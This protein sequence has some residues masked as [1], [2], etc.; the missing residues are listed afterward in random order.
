L[1]RRAADALAIVAAFVVL[2]SCARTASVLVGYSWDWAPDEGLALDYARRVVEAPG[3]LYGRDLIPFPAAYT[4]LLPLL[5]APVVRFTDDPLAGARA[6]AV[7]WTA[8]AALGVFLLVRRRSGVALGLV[9]VALM[10][11]PRDFSMWFLLVRVDGLMIALWLGAAVVLLPARL[12]PGT[13]ELSGA[14]L[15]TGTALLLASVL[16]KPTAIIHGAPLVLGWFMVSRRSAWRLTGAMLAGGLAA[17]ALLQLATRGGFL[18]TMRLWGVHPWH[19]GLLARLVSMFV[20]AHGPVLLLGVMAIALA[21]RRKERPLRDG[22]WLLVLGGLAVVPMLGKGGAWTNYLLP[23]YV[24]LVTL[25]CRLW[26]GTPPLAVLVPAV[27]G[28]ALLARPFPLPTPADAETSTA[29][30]S[31]VRDRGRPILATR[32]DYAYFLVRQPVEAEGS[33]LPYLVAARVPGTEQLLERVRRRHYRL[34]VALPYFWPNE[35][36]FETAL[37]E[38]YEIAGTCTLGFFYGQS[39]FVL[40]VPR[41]DGVRLTPSPGARCR[42]FAAPAASPAPAGSPVRDTP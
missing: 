33:G 15:W 18:W 22:A 24:A 38:G 10:L 5:L 40:L 28:L 2:G 12:E 27:L 13:E 23:L 42:S 17:L 8:A 1:S 25:A 26:P 21:W 31:F 9:G 19:P 4:P 20:T 36:A 41:G 29:F 34:I 30:Y 32:P 35:P 39:E 11:A 37:S 3:T 6:L 14:R 16:T 7:A